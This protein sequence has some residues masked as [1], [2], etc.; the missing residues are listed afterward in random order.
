MRFRHA[1]SRSFLAAILPMAV[2]MVIACGRQQ[3][4]VDTGQGSAE[5]SSGIRLNGAGATFPAPLYSQWA[6]AYRNATGVEINYAA[7]GSGG[8]ISQ[9]QARTVDFG[10]SDAPLTSDQLEK[11]GLIQFPAIIGGVVLAYNLPGFNGEVKLDGSTLADIFLGKIKNWDDPR[12]GQLNPGTKLPHTAITPVYRSD[13]SGTTF[14]FTSYLSK[15]SPA[16]KSS[17]GADKTVQWPAGV[18]GKGNP[19]VAGFVKQI[20]GGIGYVEYAYAKTNSLPTATLK[21]QDG[22]FVRPSSAAFTAAAAKASWDP[23]KGFAVSL[24]DQPGADSWPIVGASFI[25]I[26]SQPPDPERAREV[27][28]FFDWAFK[29]GGAAA[30]KLDYVPLPQNAIDAIRQAW[31]GIKGTNGKSVTTS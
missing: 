6:D 15:V 21:N 14:I 24:T 29:N 17:V 27:L 31:S 20:P 1:S 18:G 8:G 28:T 5:R 30:N 3:Q 19:G 25:L 4:A 11:S 13:G 22:Q 10:A 2:L 23:S 26:P 16:W 7:I 12:I 9:I